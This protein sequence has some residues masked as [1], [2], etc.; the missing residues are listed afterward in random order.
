[1]TGC[2]L[3]VVELATLATYALS[4]SALGAQ[5]VAV[6]GT[7][8]GRVT[9][10]SAG[11]HGVE[12]A[13]VSIPELSGSVRTN[14]L[15]EY[16]IQAPQGR[17]LVTVRLPGFQALSDSVTVSAASEA[18]LN[19]VLDQRVVRLDSMVT[20]AAP[21]KYISGNLSGFEERLRSHKGGYFVGDSILGAN[22]SRRLPEVLASRLNGVRFF[23]PP[24]AGP[25]VMWAVGTRA[26][27]HDE[28]G[29]LFHCTNPDGTPVRHS[30]T[31]PDLCYSNVYLDGVLIYDA[32]KMTSVVPPDLGQFSVAAIA[33][34]EFYASEASTPVQFTASP[35]GVLAIWTR[36]K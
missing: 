9:S 7:I 1:M 15:G 25:D 19:F 28:C 16:R 17:Y 22:E 33:G 24:I 27:G 23:H 20:Q 3:L 5:S 36:E 31:F 13:E 35:C 2:R 6:R 18:R 30:S 14:L 21:R 10:D 34:V 8:V 32:R 11:A 29:A 12:N 26:A 4:A